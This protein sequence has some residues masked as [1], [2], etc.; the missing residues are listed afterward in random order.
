[1]DQAV[2]DAAQAALAC[3]N[4]PKLAA[5]VR[6]DAAFRDEVLD[7]ILK[8]QRYWEWRPSPNVWRGRGRV[9]ARERD[10]AGAVREYAEP[11]TPVASEGPYD[12]LAYFCLLRLAGDDER[13]S[14]LAEEW[15]GLPE[16]LPAFHK[17]DGSP[18]PSHSIRASILVRLLDD[19]P[20]DP[21]DLIQRAEAYPP[22]SK[23]ERAY[24]VGAALLRAGRLGEAVRRFEES[25][26]IEPEW[27]EH[28]L[29]A[30]GLAL[31]HHRLGHPDEARRWLD[32]AERWLTEL[33]RIY[34]TASPSAVARQQ[35]PVS[36]VSWVYAQVLRR[37]AT[38]LILDA[39][40]PTDPFAR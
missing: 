36:F 22:F 29:N 17:P 37:E 2:D 32:R 39:S 31:A 40:F 13:A 4:D 10:W 18:E 30:Y 27:F 5:L 1:V 16:L 25:L 14:R 15:R 6:S 9:R 23:G 24:V 7:E 11:A 26:A 8:P 34:A 33:D 20:H 21:V 38:R 3:W 28:G 19:P 12:L 35:V